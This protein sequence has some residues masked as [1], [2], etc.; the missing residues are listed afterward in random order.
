MLTGAKVPAS[1]LAYGGRLL[2]I[3]AAAYAGSIGGA[4]VFGRSLAPGWHDANPCGLVATVGLAAVTPVA[5]WA[6]LLAVIGSLVILAFRLPLWTCL[7][8]VL[9][10][11]RVAY[12]VRS[13]WTV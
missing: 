13:A 10:F 5:S 8:V 4:M 3:L 11:A 2:L 1:A 9:F 12:V 6:L 7:F